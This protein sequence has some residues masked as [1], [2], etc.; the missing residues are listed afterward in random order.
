MTV[1]EAGRTGANGI[2]IRN[3]PIDVQRSV[4]VDRPPTPRRAL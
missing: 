4:R 2:A 1:G 3:G